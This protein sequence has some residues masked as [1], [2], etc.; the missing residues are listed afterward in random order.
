MSNIN[1][2]KLFLLLML[3]SG[4]YSFIWLFRILDDVEIENIAIK[5]KLGK[6]ITIFCLLIIIFLIISIPMIDKLSFGL[7]IID[8][9]L[10]LNGVLAVGMILTLLAFS[11]FFYYLLKTKYYLEEKYLVRL[12]NAFS[13]VFLYFFFCISIIMIQ[14]KINKIKTITKEVS[15]L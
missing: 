15:T 2:T 1:L 12:P 11:L 8:S 14:S 4:F 9:N 6:G 3:T 10:L 7:R 13:V 5:T